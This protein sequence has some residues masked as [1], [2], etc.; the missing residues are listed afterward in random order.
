MDNNISFRLIRIENI[1][2]ATFPEFLNNESEDIKFSVSIHFGI[3][4]KEKF[5]GCICEFQ[6]QDNEKVFLKLETVCEFG[7]QEEKWNEFITE[8]NIEFPI[9]FLR[10]LA[11][12]TVGTS[13]GILHSKTENS[14]MNEFILPTINIIEVIKDNQVFDLNEISD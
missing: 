7:I 6:F 14:D 13:R 12:I 4:K 11:M 10:H 2:F 1:Q 8:T 9:E 3:D 5:I